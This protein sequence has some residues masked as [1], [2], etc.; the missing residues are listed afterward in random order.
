VFSW[1][2]IAATGDRFTSFEPYVPSV[3]DAGTVAFQAALQD[4]RTRVFAGSG[5]TADEV[6]GA[7]ALA[8]VTSHPDL[9]N[10]GAV[11]F[12]GDLTGGG[13]G[14]FI[15]HD[16]S[17][18]TV[19]DTDGAFASI[20]PLGPT[21]NESGMVAFRADPAPNM[22]GVFA[23]DGGAVVT[24][25]DTDGPWS[26]FHGL[27][28]VNRGGTV[29]FRADRKDGVQGIYAF[30]EGSIRTVVETGDRFETLA[31]FPSIS[32]DG[33][34]AFA[35]TLSG[36]GE[37]AFTQRGD[38]PPSTHDPDGAFESYRGALITSA[39]QL[40]WMA[41]PRGGNRGLFAGPDPE[42]NLILA[43]GDPLLG[44]EVTDVRSNPV[45]VNAVGQVAIAAV[46]AD[47]RQLILRAD[48]GD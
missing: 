3:N 25:A 43:L 26:E 30:D 8:G 32:D 27:P 21:M 22:S 33:T 14:V 12:Y 46:L 31:P 41:R 9:N 34:V 37:G 40:M 1:T 7:A 18:Q 15:L 47:G 13:Q 6:A 38:G 5:G 44:S 23:G 45:S 24:V 10:A 28:V 39:G 4:G 20:G 29:V 19:A 16:G 48:P 2:V 42:A 17:L 35:A 11:S 36:G